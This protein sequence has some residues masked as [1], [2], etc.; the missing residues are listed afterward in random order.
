MHL[1]SFA[2][3]TVDNP[4]IENCHVVLWI[5]KIAELF[6]YQARVIIFGMDQDIRFRNTQSRLIYVLHSPDLLTTIE[7]SPRTTDGSSWTILTH[8]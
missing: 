6:Y 2:T 3:R 5:H 4:F 7:R 8:Y 1:Y